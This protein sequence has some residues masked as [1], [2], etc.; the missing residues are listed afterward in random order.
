M[1]AA[2]YAVYAWRAAEGPSGGSWPGL[3]FAFAGTALIV[4]EC[5]LSLRKKYPASPLGRMQTWL[6]A[7]IWLGLAAFVLIL[8][9]AG[10][11][12]GQGLARLLMWLFVV[13]TASGVWGLVMQAWLPGRMRE[14]VT[15]ETLYDQ[16]PEVI[17][18]LRLE[19]DER[20]EF[21][22]ADLGLDEREEEMIRAGGRKFYFEIGRASCRE[23]V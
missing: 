21:L 18:A 23:R 14:L 13:I 3:A 17:T 12:F 1:A 16:I 2:F 22:T 4:F 7:H 15:R 8:L 19:A 5:L 6:K 9:H 10:L 20:I 11:D